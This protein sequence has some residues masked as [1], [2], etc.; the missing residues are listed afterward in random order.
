MG[1]LYI[2]VI[3]ERQHLSSKVTDAA[4]QV[5]NASEVEGNST[6]VA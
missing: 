2:E 1:L 6:E 4:A 5:I 3:E